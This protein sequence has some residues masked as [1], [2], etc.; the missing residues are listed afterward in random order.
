MLR[1]VS[2]CSLPCYPLTHLHRPD[3]QLLGLREPAQRLV[4][5][6]EVGGGGERARVPVLLAVHPLRHREHIGLHV[7]S[8]GQLAH[9]LQRTAEVA[10]R[11]PS[12][13]SVLKRGRGKRRGWVGGDGNNREQGCKAERSKDLQGG[14]VAPVQCGAVPAAVHVRVAHEEKRKAQHMAC[15]SCGH[16]VGCDW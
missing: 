2:G 7:G 14:G 11:V 8:L 1:S 5:E 6:R 16:S 10:R 3:L 4:R 13:C 9:A 12:W 15:V